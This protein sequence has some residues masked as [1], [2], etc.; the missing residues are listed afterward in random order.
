LAIPPELNRDN[1][2]TLPLDADA[3]SYEEPVVMAGYVGGGR[4]YSIG[5]EPFAAGMYQQNIA[6]RAGRVG[7][8]VKEPDGHRNAMY[9]VNVPSLPGMSGGPLMTLRPTDIEGVSFVTAVGVISSSRL[10]APILLNHCEEGETWV[11]PIVLG[12]GRK[13]S[14]RGTP[15]AIADAIH[16]GTVAAYGHKASEFEFV[17][18]E[19]NGVALTT[20]RKRDGASDES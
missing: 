17:R 12:L 13:V 14:I 11:S 20:L 7:E 5:D 2:R 18:E 8:L 15:T 10:G 6:V 16:D 1:F 4:V 9:R 3:F 19:S